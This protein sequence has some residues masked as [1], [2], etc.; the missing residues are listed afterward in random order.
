VLGLQSAWATTIPVIDGHSNVQWNDAAMYFIDDRGV[1]GYV[2]MCIKNNADYLYLG[3]YDS[4]NDIIDP[5]DMVNIFFDLNN[6]GA[7]DAASP[8]SEGF[9]TIAPT[10]AAFTGLW[11]SYPDDL[12]SDTI[13]P[14]PTGIENAVARDYHG[15]FYEIAINLHTSVIHAIPG[16]TIGFGICLNDPGNFYPGTYGFSAEWPWGLLPGAV[17]TLGHL[18]LAQTTNMG[19]HAAD[20]THPETFIL[21]QSFPNPFNPETTIR[22]ELPTTSNVH[23]AVYNIK[24]QLVKTLVDETETAGVRTVT[25]NGRSN[26]GSALPSGMYVCRMIASG[27]VF[28]CKMMLMK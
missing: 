13:V 3:F 15:L 8:S 5:L 9:I 19:E 14:S 21:H 1:L 18:T 10:S 2:N 22:Y 11:G 23:L 27:N 25:W 12:G 6:D 16:Q 17:A 24:G 4:N 20:S 7:W 28:Q 26:D